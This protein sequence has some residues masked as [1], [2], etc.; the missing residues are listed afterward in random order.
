[1]AEICEKSEQ[2][3]GKNLTKGDFRKNVENLPKTLHANGK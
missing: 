2:L 1:M 3:T